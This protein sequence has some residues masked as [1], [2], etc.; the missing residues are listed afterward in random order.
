MNEKIDSS[1]KG[2]PFSS[3]EVRAESSSPCL[4]DPEGWNTLD[5]L[6][7]SE[8]SEILNELET[9]ETS[10]I[11]ATGSDNFFP[12]PRDSKP[13]SNIHCAQPPIFRPRHGVSPLLPGQ[14][15]H[16]T[17]LPPLILVRHLGAAQKI[18]LQ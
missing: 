6:D 14:V 13:L 9:L 10:D 7:T 11:L 3:S 12:L 16:P 17:A 2:T 4:E 5:T 15:S 8:T 1:G 18:Q